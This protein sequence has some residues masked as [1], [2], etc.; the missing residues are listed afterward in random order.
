MNQYTNK[1][2]RD[3]CSVINK[4]LN[5]SHDNFKKKLNKTYIRKKLIIK[6]NIT[7]AD[8]LMECTIKGYAGFFHHDE[9][10]IKDKLGSMYIKENN[11]FYILTSDKD[12]IYYQIKD[13]GRNFCDILTF[14]EIFELVEL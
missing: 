5:F 10:L 4:Y 8:I 12:H 7:L 11:G 9:L 1:L 2:S 14:P 6:P 13:C 3:I